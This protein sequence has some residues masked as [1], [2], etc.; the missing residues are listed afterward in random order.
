MASEMDLLQG[1]LTELKDMKTEIKDIK[2]EL[3]TTNKRLT[4]LEQD[5]QDMKAQMNAGFTEV[6]TDIKAIYG[7]LVKYRAMWRSF[8]PTLNT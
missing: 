1:I 3:K 4:T 8:K 2:T 5:Q 6:K 7:I